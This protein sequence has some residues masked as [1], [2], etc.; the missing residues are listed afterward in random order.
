[1]AVI[2]SSN[3]D[4]RKFIYDRQYVIVQFC[5]VDECPTCDELLAAFTRFSEEYKNITFVEMNA[6]DNPTAKMLIQQQQKPFY[7]VYKEGLLVR[8]GIVSTEAELS[9]MLNALPNIK[10]DL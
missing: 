4:L 9:E 3:D 2:R 8:C 1:M 7:G 10:F 6:D 5:T